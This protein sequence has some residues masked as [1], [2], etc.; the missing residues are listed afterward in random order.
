MRLFPS[1]Y[2]EAYIPIAYENGVAQA[3]ANYRSVDWRQARPIIA[4][5]CQAKYRRQHDGNLQYR[6]LW[7]KKSR[8]RRCRRELNI[9]DLPQAPATFD[10]SPPDMSG[11]T[12]FPVPAF[13][14]GAKTGSITTRTATLTVNSSDGMLP[15]HWI[16]IDGATCALLSPL[17]RCRRWE[18]VRS[19]L[20][21]AIP[22]P[23]LESNR[24]R[25][26]C[27]SLVGAIHRAG[28]HGTGKAVP[29]RLRNDI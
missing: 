27:R 8:S 16:F 22:S 4:D 18:L 10:T 25:Q 7:V 9:H 2:R 23:D 20:Y 1:A 11:Y 24:N 12:V 3:L 17:P 26:R 13:A 21:P 5:Q 19:S 14:D 29:R 15:N 6:R 28:L